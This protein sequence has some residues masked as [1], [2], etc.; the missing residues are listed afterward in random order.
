LT[1][2]IP[3]KIGQLRQLQSLDLSG[4][5][6]SGVI[7]MK[8]ADLYFLNYLNLSNNHLFVRGGIPSST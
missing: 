7:S 6:L 8:M 3:Q 4:N 2:A 1:G 5:Q